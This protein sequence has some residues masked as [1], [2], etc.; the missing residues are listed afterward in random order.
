VLGLG[1]VW[2]KNSKSPDRCVIVNVDTGDV[3]KS[4]SSKDS[5]KDVAD[6]I[7]KSFEQDEDEGTEEDSDEGCSDGCGEGDE[8]CGG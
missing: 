4:L 7:A 8:G 1:E 5:E 6:A 2:R 3:V